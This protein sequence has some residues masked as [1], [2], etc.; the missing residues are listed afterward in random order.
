L[1]GKVVLVY[2]RARSATEAA[3]L[4]ECV[5]K[6][7]GERLFL[8]G[9]AVSI[10]R[11]GTDWTEGLRHW[12]AWDAIAEFVVFESMDEFRTRQARFTPSAAAAEMQLCYPSGE[13]GF[14]VEPS[15][16]P[17]E[18][19]TQLEPGSTVLAFPRS[20]GGGPR[21]CSS[22]ET[23][24]CCC[25][26]RAGTRPGTSSFHAASCR[27]TLVRASMK[28]RMAKRKRNSF[29]GGMNV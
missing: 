2:S 9:T 21:S 1:Q 27:W 14:P 4:S 3:A 20:G 22:R 5:F 13:A 18:P 16:V 26:S 17:V 29:G 7:F 12:I 11:S 24:E 8:V 19:E 28:K 15:G 6:R 10:P 23:T 25:I